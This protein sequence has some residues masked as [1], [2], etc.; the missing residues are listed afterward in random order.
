MI[1]D[2]GQREILAP[3]LAEFD[4]YVSQWY[5]DNDIAAGGIV[6]EDRLGRGVISM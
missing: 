3:L 5:T 6:T 4:E 1:T 2:P